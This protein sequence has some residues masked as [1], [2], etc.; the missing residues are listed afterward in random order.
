[1]I[2]MIRTLVVVITV[3]PAGCDKVFGLQPVAEADGAAASIAFVQ[4]SSQLATAAMTVTVSYPLPQMATDLNVVV[5]SWHDNYP[6]IASVTDVPGNS[7][8]SLHVDTIG[9]YHQKIFYASNINAF[10][11][12]VVTIAFEGPPDFATVEI[13]EYSGIATTDPVDDF[14]IGKGSDDMAVSDD[15]TTTNAFDLIVGA[16]TTSYSKTGTGAMFMQRVVL[17]ASAASGDLIED[18]V[19]TRAGV[20]DAI[21][22]LMNPNGAAVWIMTVAAF[23]GVD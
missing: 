4:G 18:R 1:M 9:N 6:G 7:Y 3:L 12:N 21:A 20:Y 10:D 17:P 2:T 8:T 23:K 22:P 15:V 16:D 11:D 13:A 19:V 5:V 14:A